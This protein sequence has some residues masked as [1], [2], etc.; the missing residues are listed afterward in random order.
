MNDTGS[1][2]RQAARDSSGA[3]PGSGA[4]RRD[5]LYQEL[6]RTLLADLAEAG[7][8]PGERLPPE[9]ELSQRYDVSRP[10]VREALIALEVQGLIEVRLGSGAYLK[11]LPDGAE[12]AAFAVSAFEVTEARLLVEPEVAGLAAAQI[13][14]QEL[15]QLA[16]LVDGI[17]QENAR[18][19]GTESADR[20]F[21]LL[22]ARASRN[23]ALLR[24]VE[25]L[26]A[27]R[28]ASPE[29]ALLYAKARAA[30]IQPV[31]EEHT[32]ILRALE[33]R[34]P[35]AA[36]AAM[37]AHLNAVLDSLLFA[38][39]ERAIEEARRASLSRKARIAHTME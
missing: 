24:I 32:A 17:A 8:R 36:R 22:I 23:T 15:A 39:E 37:R 12:P 16:A 11:A 3:E 27:L 7:V 34:D 31:V 4:P 14:A 9:R 29:T 13:D 1:M 19:A 25:D 10:T 2:P 18:H 30:N 20:D 28:A 5:R 38:T 26:W 6:A 35:A 21:H 33:A